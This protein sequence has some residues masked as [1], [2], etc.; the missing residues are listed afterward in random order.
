[1]G[2]R[3]RPEAS[4][5]LTRDDRDAKGACRQACPFHFERRPGRITVAGIPRLPRL[6]R[7]HFDRRPRR[8]P[9]THHR[10][11]QSAA[12]S[13]CPGRPLDRTAGPPGRPAPGRTGA[14]RAAARLAARIVA[15]LAARAGCPLPPRRTRRANRHPGV[16]R[17]APGSGA[18]DARRHRATHP[19]AQRPGEAGSRSAGSGRRGC[20]GCR[21][22]CCA[23]PPA[24]A[25]AA[26]S[27]HPSRSCG[28]RPADHHR[29]TVPLPGPAL[30]C[31]A[32]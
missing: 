11:A 7:R 28:S 15:P 27:P 32:L 19:P 1:M 31:A 23:S 12:A 4:R 8:R 5:G 3:L 29:V 16:G 18:P 26:R 25:P 6:P 17:D 9:A 20:P 14:Q 24:P 21:G 10:T 13:S 30:D 2:A 22:S